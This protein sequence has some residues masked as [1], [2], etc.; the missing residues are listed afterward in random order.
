MEPRLKIKLI[1]A[2]RQNL[3]WRGKPLVYGDIPTLSDHRI[4][5][6]GMFLVGPGTCCPPRH[7]MP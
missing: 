2:L 3:Y 4:M 7:G 6:A 1:R 5:P